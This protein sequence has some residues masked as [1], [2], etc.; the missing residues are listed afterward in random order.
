MLLLLGATGC[1]PEPA[2]PLRVGTNVWPGYEPL[3]LARELGY[4]DGQP[5]KLVEY[6]NSTEV[7]RA[8]RNGVLE[9][10]ALTL[11]EV[12]MLAEKGLELRIVLIMDISHGSDVVIGRPGLEDI[13]GLKGKRV[14]VENTAL[15]AYVLTRTLDTA[16]FALTDIEVVPLG[17]NEHEEAFTAGTVDAVVTFDPV[18]TKLL[19]KG[20]RQLFDS[21]EI[22]GEIVDVL[23][24]N[25]QVL[26]T[27]PEDVQRLLRGWFRALA[28]HQAQP[29]DAAQR[30]GAREHLSAEEFASA[31]E[32]LRIPDRELNLE[33]LGG[34]APTLLP[35]AQRLAEV[36][37]D[38]GLFQGAVDTMS[39]LAP[40]PLEGLA[41]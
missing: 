15:G 13:H 12:L 35:A 3:Y 31:L 32:G 14:G 18:R 30:M 38:R 4:Y 6:P 23:A 28:Y 34:E 40:A 1:T 25:K 7:M 36:M 17:V 33:M 16:G 10:A 26:E 29:R 19:A 2:P 20:G 21:S 5:V 9:A 37:I 8:Y 41:Q 22:P 24:V 11:D 39:L 27:R